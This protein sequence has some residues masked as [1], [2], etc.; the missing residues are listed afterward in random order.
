AAMVDAGGAAG[1]HAARR[2]EAGDGILAGRGG[3]ARAE[4]E[5]VAA[6]A[7]VVFLA[8]IAVRVA[9]PGLARGGIG[10]ASG[11]GGFPLLIGL[12]PGRHGRRLRGRAFLGGATARER[13]R[14]EQGE[15]G[16]A[17]EARHR[18]ILVDP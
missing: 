2:G 9:G 10:G 1:R 18:S 4:R 3:L 17:N 6:A 16:E 5:A 12:V 14:A 13:E 8:A 11:V 15:D 7:V